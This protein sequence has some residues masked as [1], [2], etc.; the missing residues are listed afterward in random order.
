MSFPYSPGRT[1]PIPAVRLKASS[2]DGSR[3]IPDVLAFI[4]TAADL[5]VTPLVLVQLLRLSSLRQIDADGLGG[6]IGT[7]DLYEFDIEVPGL[8][9]ETVETI[10]HPD[11]P[12][13]LLGRPFLNLFRLT[14]DGPNQVVEFH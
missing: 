7:Y 10:A 11:E 13:L 8:P 3:S 5:C 9:V 6:Q 2:P 4:D 1:P 12:Y 14:L